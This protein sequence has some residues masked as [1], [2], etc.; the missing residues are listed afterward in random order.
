MALLPIRI[1]VYALRLR[2]F[3]PIDVRNL[4]PLTYDQANPLEDL[5]LPESHKKMILATVQT[6]LERQ[7]IQR[8]IQS[9][10]LTQDILT[11]DFIIGKGR[12]LLIMLHGEPGVGK[13]A[14]AEAIAHSTKR[15]LFP[16]SCNDINT[17]S[18]RAV[19]QALDEVFRLAHMWDCVLCMSDQSEFLPC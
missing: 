2:K 12:G 8:Q 1:F 11:Q 15:P 9:Q 17:P 10:N 4:K 18:V 5:Q 14:T 3:L 7:S 6:H 13:T 16:I 19:E